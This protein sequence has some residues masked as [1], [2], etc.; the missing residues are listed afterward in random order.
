MTWDFVS[1]PRESWRS[2]SRSRS[3]SPDPLSSLS[4]RFHESPSGLMVP[5]DATLSPSQSVRFGSLTGADWA[6]HEVCPKCNTSY[7]VGTAHKCSGSLFSRWA[8]QY[9]SAGASTA[10]WGQYQTYGGVAG[11]TC[12]TCGIT[13][14]AGRIHICLGAVGAGRQYDPGMGT[15]PP[16]PTEKRSLPVI[17]Y[18][19]WKVRLGGYRLGYGQQRQLRSTGVPGGYI[20]TPG[21]QTARCSGAD[22]CFVDGLHVTVPNERH[23]CGLYVLAN[24]DE[25]ATHVAPVHDVVVGAVL[26]WGK[27][28][29]HEDATGVEGWRAQYAQVVALLDMKFSDENDALALDIS[30]AYGVP[31]LERDALELMVREF[32]D[33]VTE[34]E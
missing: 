5:D 22:Y 12:A 6:M 21:V 11:V 16:L 7:P 25:V 24:L 26:G 28:V 2:R 14:P 10:P 29:L 3:E 8:L 33:P 17:G 15:P 27:V 34:G 4:E 30:K 19:A 13:V 18:R 32:G 9:P 20:W 31:V 1:R 23:E